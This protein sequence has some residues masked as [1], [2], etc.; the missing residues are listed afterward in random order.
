MIADEQLTYDVN[1]A[2]LY[3]SSYRFL[4]LVRFFVARIA[5]RAFLRMKQHEVH[6]GAK[7]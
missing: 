1:V 5:A 7:E 3:S 2:I 4:I 6:L